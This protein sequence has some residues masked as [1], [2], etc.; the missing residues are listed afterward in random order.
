MI[1]TERRFGADDRN[2]KILTGG[3][4][5][6]SNLSLIKKEEKKKYVNLKTDN[7]IR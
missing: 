7:I 4:R 1:I 2:G 6:G 3:G 5:G